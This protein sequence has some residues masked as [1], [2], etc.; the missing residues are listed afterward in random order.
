[1]LAMQE[2]P[3]LQACDTLL[4]VTNISFDI[5]GLELFLPLVVGARVV[6]A[7]KQTVM[8]AEQLA[9]ALR[10]HGA[11]V[12]QAT[13]ATWRLLLDS[14]WRADEPM[15]M[16]CGG[17]A[18]APDL[19][20]QLL[21]LGGA[22]WNLYGPT[23]TTIWST[24]YPIAYQVQPHGPLPIGRPIANT[25]IYV[26]DKNLQPVPI[27]VPGEIL[28]GGVGLARGYFKRADLTAER[29]IPN[30]VAA[31]FIAPGQRLYRT[32]D[33]ARYLP[34]GSLQ[35]L[36]RSDQQV[37]LR[38]YRIELGEIE[39]VLSRYAGV[40]EA[41]VMLREGRGADKGL[42]AYIVAR[43][44]E[45]LSVSSVQRYLRELLPDYM[46]P[47]SVV[48]V[49]TISLTPNGKVDRK[50]LQAIN[51]SRTSLPVAEDKQ[52][53]PL[54][55][56]LISIWQDVLGLSMRGEGVE[57][58]DSDLAPTLGIDDNFFEKGGHSLLATQVVSRIRHMFRV[59]LSLHSFFE[60]PTIA[61]LASLLE[62][63]MRG[64]SAH[65]VDTLVPVE[66]PNDSR[67][68]GQ[69]Y[70]PLSFAQ[71]RL[72]FLDQWYPG[73]AWYNIPLS[74]RL[75]GRLEISALEQSLATVIQRHEALRTTFAWR[76]GQP[77]QSIAPS[78]SIQ[79]PV[80]DLRDWTAT[81]R[82]QQVMR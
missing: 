76:E 38:G 23:E 74:L 20:D 62:E 45:T 32:G 43:S 35:Y 12:M 4:A 33:M 55:E 9:R 77:V 27:G 16:L 28:I 54:Q 52:L 51:L 72:W 3:G 80:I 22:V 73:S 42:V 2:Q 50:A 24:I 34:D 66:R 47:T 37:K 79:M 82:D 8:D 69:V 41:V 21:G 6:I 26:V 59:D 49:E 46:V 30:P 53:T 60:A 48:F 1:M 63:L 5:A 31:Q 70:L 40:R 25:Q 57:T 64:S 71:E 68:G 17:E 10:E 65:L 13:P 14:D 75:A 19:A 61:A 58:S 36:G 81:E 15:K 18:L 7:G 11:T 67:L 44:G 29:M 39:A 78:L 56:L